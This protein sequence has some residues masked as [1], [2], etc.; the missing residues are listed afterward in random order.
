MDTLTTTNQLVWTVQPDADPA[1]PLALAP[2]TLVSIDT[3]VQPTA[4]PLAIADLQTN[5]A[6]VYVGG[7]AIGSQAT[8]TAALETIAGMLG[9][10]IDTCAWPA[11]RYSHVAM[12]RARLIDRYPSAS[13]VNKHLSAL[14]GT[15]KAAW[16]M[17]LLDSDS[18]ARAV[19]IAAVKAERPDAAAGRAI[20]IGEVMAL[21]AVCKDG[22]D[23]GARNA[24]L[25]ALASIGGLRRAEIVN[26]DLAHWNAAAGVLTVLGKR[27]KTRTVPITGGGRRALDAWLAVRGDQAGPL[28]YAY[29]RGDHRQDRR[30]TPQSILIVFDELAA[31]A[32]VAPF[33]PHDFRRTFAGDLL[34]AG[35][36]LSTVQKMMGHSDPKTTAGYDR[37]GERAKVSASKL[38]HFPF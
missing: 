4:A 6:R 26:L 1:A 25:L 31:A 30:L 33:S 17:G 8:M 7:L 3:E 32:G 13:T 29:R 19:N 20:E 12:I 14:R 24:A 23:A 27:N 5:P 38:L 22:T 11:L 10:N 15:I 35:V 9:A 37:R 2:A 36:D 18:Y 28:F 21:V 16:Q 34:D